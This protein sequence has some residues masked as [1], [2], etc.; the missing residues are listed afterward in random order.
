[1]KDAEGYSLPRDW[2]DQVVMQYAQ[3]VLEAHQAG[4]FAT[5]K[6]AAD[7]SEAIYLAARGNDAIAH[8]KAVTEDLRRQMKPRM[9]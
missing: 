3:A 5:N 7:L 1:M 6:A 9:R 4:L 2:N 8:M